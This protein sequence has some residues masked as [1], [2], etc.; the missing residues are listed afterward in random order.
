MALLSSVGD[1]M[2]LKNVQGRRDSLECYHEL[3]GVGWRRGR[4]FAHGEDH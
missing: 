1:N 4:S 2:E 3:D